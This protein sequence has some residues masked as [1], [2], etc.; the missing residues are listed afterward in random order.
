[1]SRFSLR[2]ACLIALLCATAA[3]G[4]TDAPPDDLLTLARGAVLVTASADPAGALALIDGD[5][6]S[7]WSVSTRKKPPPHSFTF[8]LI[9]PAQLTAVGIDGAGP[10]PGGVAGG[11]AATVRVEGSSEGPTGGFSEIAR[12]EAAAEGPTMVAVATA[13][14]LRWLRFTVE[15]AQDPA[16]AFLYLDE[17]VAE[18]TVTPPGGDRFAG[19]FSAGKFDLI[20]LRQTGGEVTGCF[21]DNGGRSTG[22]LEGAV[23]NGVALLNWVSDQRIRG[24]A[25][26]TLDSQGGLS[27][28]RYRDKS[29]KA[30]GGPPAPGETTPCS[31]ATAPANPIS[32][33][34]ADSGTARL[35]GIHFAH[36][37][38]VPLPSAEPALVRLLEALQ[39]NPD[40]FVV[41]EGH[42]DSAGA[43]A[44]NLSLSER[45]AA[46]VVGWLVARGI[47]P[48]RL[49]PAGKGETA[50]VAS[51][52]TADGRALNRRVDVVRR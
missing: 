20:E 35:Y 37:S 3:S 30:W 39:D 14:P 18:G 48:D 49:V 12:L 29:R 22:T 42:T 26:L 32:A 47:G 15:G 16:A 52:D 6:T 8:E 31:T 41:I 23:V 5:P 38:D 24:S 51:N 28:V 2:S 9:A 7:H 1:M 10:R 25:I 11:S 21:S 34:L 33:A 44:Y 50:P 17:V 19:V 13:E 27:G 4:Q 43:D 46:S 36:D 45:R 40:F